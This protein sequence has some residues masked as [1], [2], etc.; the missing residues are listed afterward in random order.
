MKDGHLGQGEV[1][2][3]VVRFLANR[4]KGPIL[5]CLLRWL[6]HTIGSDAGIVGIP[7]R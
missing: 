6:K 5:A 3:S 7:L 2:T 4:V 1:S